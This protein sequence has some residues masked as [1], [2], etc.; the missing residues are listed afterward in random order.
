MLRHRSSDRSIRT[1]RMISNERSFELFAR[2][3]QSINTHQPIFCFFF[4]FI[5][6]FWIASFNVL[7]D[8]SSLYFF[9]IFFVSFFFFMW[10]KFMRDRVRTQQPQANKKSN[11]RSNSWWFIFPNAPRDSFFFVFSCDE[12]FLLVFTPLRHS[13]DNFFSFFWFIKINSIRMDRS[14]ER[15]KKESVLPMTQVESRTCKHGDYCWCCCF[16]CNSLNHHHHFFSLKRSIKS[17]TFYAL[18]FWYAFVHQF[19]F[20][21]E[22]REWATE[23]YGAENNKNTKNTR[24]FRIS[25]WVFFLCSWPIFHLDVKILH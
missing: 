3:F 14:I 4:H 6:M 16:D 10:K 21:H 2:W 15:E 24:Q 19:C 5:Q 9:A 7:Y 25:V 11:E 20:A 18:A 8:F 13:I 22:F 1:L 23:K 12:L 17:A